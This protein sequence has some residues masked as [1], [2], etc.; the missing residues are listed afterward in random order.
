MA[1]FHKLTKSEPEG[2]SPKEGRAKWSIKMERTLIRGANRYQRY[3]SKTLTTAQIK[4][5][6]TTVNNKKS[7]Y[8]TYS[9]LYL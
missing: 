5:K 3:Y 8:Y 9:N 4:N 7:I 2:E 1:L 6:V